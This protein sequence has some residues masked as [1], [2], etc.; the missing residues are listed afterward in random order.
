MLA[1]IYLLFN[2]GYKASAGDRLLR[3]DLCQEAIRLGSLL[4]AHPAGRTPRSH[5]LLALMLLQHSRR[6]ARV[7][8][9]IE[10]ARALDVLGPVRAAVDVLQAS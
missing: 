4:V 7:R 1:A 10:L 5:A 6:D 2:E 9:V 8:E 3:E